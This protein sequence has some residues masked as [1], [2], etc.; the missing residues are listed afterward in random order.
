MSMQVSTSHLQGMQ[1]DK[2]QS[3]SYHSH[4]PDLP[5]IPKTNCFTCSN[6]TSFSGVI[7]LV[8]FY[9][10]LKTESQLQ[11]FVHAGDKEAF[12]EAKLH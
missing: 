12:I 4:L 3:F 1:G 6:S 7:V 11:Y 9:N 5:L 2:Q 8:N 10:D